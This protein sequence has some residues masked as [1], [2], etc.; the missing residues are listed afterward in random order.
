MNECM[1]WL[2]VEYGECYDHLRL[3]AYSTV[4]FDMAQ[5]GYTQREPLP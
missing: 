4:W 2:C 5:D 3:L 1:A